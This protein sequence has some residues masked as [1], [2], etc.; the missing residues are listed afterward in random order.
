MRELVC[1]TFEFCGLTDD[2]IVNIRDI[3]DVI[4]G[5]IAIEKPAF[6]KVVGEKGTEIANVGVVIHRR[7]A[8]VEAHD[9]GFHG[10]KGLLGTC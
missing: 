6:D 9:A 8:R 10:G 7:S 1:S 2:F 4:D 3:H 5:V